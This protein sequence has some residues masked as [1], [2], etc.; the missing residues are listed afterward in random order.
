M[1][2]ARGFRPSTA[3]SVARGR[4]HGEALQWPLS[5]RLPH[6]RMAD[7]QGEPGAGGGD[8]RFDRAARQPQIFRRLV[9]AVREGKGWRYVGRAG[10]GFNADTLRTVYEKLAPLITDKKPVPE[11]VPDVGNTTW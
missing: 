6:T 1:S 3:L 11:K 2:E 10:T 5:F 9:L 4:H 8:R 7:G